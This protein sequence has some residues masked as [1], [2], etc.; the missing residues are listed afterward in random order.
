VVDLWD[1]TRLNRQAASFFA[2]QVVC[3]SC[4]EVIGFDCIPSVDI[5]T[6]PPV[7]RRLIPSFFYMRQ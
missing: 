3:G 7:Y 1:P 5:P 4:I 6:F 2:A